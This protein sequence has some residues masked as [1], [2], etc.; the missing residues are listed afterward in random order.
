M[1]LLL[2]VLGAALVLLALWDIF[3]TL[4]HPRGF[5]FV[6]RVLFRALWAVSR[7]WNR[8]T[9]RSSEL[10]GPVGLLAT[11]IAWAAVVVLGFA[12]VYWPHMPGG[13]FYAAP[14]PPT[15]DLWSALYLSLVSVTTLG[16]GD[17]VP[18]T[19]PLRMLVPIQAL[20]GFVLLT[21]AISWILQVYPTLVRRRSFARRLTSMARTDTLEVVRHGDVS[22]ACALVDEVSVGVTT[23]EVDLMQY[24]ESYFFRENEPTHSLAATLPFVSSLG[25]AAAAADAMEVRHAGAMLELAV[26]SLAATLAESYLDGQDDTERSLLAFQEDHQ[27]PRV[28]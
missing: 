15:A 7:W 16:F 27:Q 18:A 26:D 25:E 5:G 19:D 24:A 3:H 1:T 13:F 9:G 2:T 21:A 4:W 17:I 28:R 20:I 8:R 11:A 12:L 6:A 23:V 14:P 22:V 10:A